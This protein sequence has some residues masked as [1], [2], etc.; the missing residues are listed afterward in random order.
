MALERVRVGADPR[1]TG[2]AGTT[3]GAAM[4]VAPVGIAFPLTRPEL[5]ADAVQTPLL[6]F[7]LSIFTRRCVNTDNIAL[8]NECWYLNNKARLKRRIL[9]YA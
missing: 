5:L 8:F 9:K 7:A 4:R 6:F 3:N 2:R 1:T